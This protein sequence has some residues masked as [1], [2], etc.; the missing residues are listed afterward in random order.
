MQEIT[1]VMWVNL[2]IFNQLISRQTELA[3]E[4]LEIVMDCF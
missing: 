3:K 2:H 1:D 4:V